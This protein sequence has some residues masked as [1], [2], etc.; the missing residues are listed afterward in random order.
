MRPNNRPVGNTI[1][2]YPFKVS[3]YL[4]GLIGLNNYLAATLTTWDVLDAPGDISTPA[5]GLVVV[6][7]AAVAAGMT[8]FLSKRRVL[9]NYF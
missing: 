2:W 8:I 5:A 3:S 9:K 1:P 7:A 4:L 6:G